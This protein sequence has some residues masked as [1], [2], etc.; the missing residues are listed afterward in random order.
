MKLLQFSTVAALALSCLAVN[1]G[2]WSRFRGPDGS[3]V[4]SDSESL[5]TMWSP[6]ANL[7]WKTEMPGPGASSPIIVGDKAFVTCYSGYGLTQ[8]A[9]GEIENLVRHLV[10]VDLKTGKVAWKKDVK[11]SLP[12]D[13]YTGIGVTA[14]GYASHTPVSDGT[15]VYAFFGKSGVHAFDMEGNKLWQADVGKESDPAKWGS[16]SSP[17]VHGDTVI[18]TASAESQSIIAFDKTSGKEVWR[19]EAEGLDGMWGTPTLVKVDET[20]TDLVMCVA[21]ELWGLDPVTGAMRWYADA[22]GAEQAYSSVILDGKRVFAFTG[23]GGGSVAV[24]AGGSGN[25]SETNTVWTGSET[26]SFASPVRHGSSVYI[27]T[28]GV[29]TVV[30]Q[31]TGKKVSQMRLSGAQQTGGR[32]GSLDYP[33]PVVV[34]DRMFYMNG[35]GQMFVFDLTGEIKQVAVNRVTTDKEIFWGS[36]AVSNGNMVIRSAKYLYCVAD[37]GETVDPDA[38]VV[39]GAEPEAPAAARGGS[40]GGNRQRFDPAAMFNGMDKDKDGLVTEAEL[41]GN[42][43]AERLMTLDTDSDKKISKA[44]FTKG[45]STL[46]SRGGSRSGGGRSGG[47][48]GGGGSYGGRGNDSRPDRPQRP[49]MASEK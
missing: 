40:G 48:S 22:T 26:S 36:P 19:Q 31:T 20:R 25:I 1:A 5:P 4:A 12:E 44:E 29:V 16:S 43:M 46:F 14:H 11:V 15:N 13:P 17:I 34:G 24:D 27:V 6:S 45:I 33:S 9:P 28:R 41:E 37:K 23:R 7:A 18:V 2:D 42:R 10:C 21:K 38:V 3:G 47:R 35:S 32:F 39:A 8:E 49:K 30:D